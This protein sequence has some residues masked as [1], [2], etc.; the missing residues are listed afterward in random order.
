[1]KRF[2]GRVAL[3][4]GGRR[5][6]GASIVERLRA[7]GARVANL[8][9]EPPARRSRARNALEVACDVSDEAQVREAIASVVRWAGRLDVLVNNA[10]LADPH[11]AP[12]DALALEDWRRVLD[13]NL[14]GPFLVTKHA[15]P[16]LR[17]RKGT[18]INIASTRAYMSEPDT[19]AYAAS[20]GGLVALTHALALSLGPAI[21]V[22]GVAPGWIAT[23]GAGA[24]RRIDHAQHPVGRVGRPAD[25]AGLVAWLAS[26]ESGF[27]TGQTLVLDGGMTRKMIYAA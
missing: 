9:R 8:D 2:Q 10:G 22:N 5:G 23:R 24:L 21:R 11:G 7:E 1:M 19:L 18:V 16:H 6:I 3:V 13:V 26:D 14:T 4:T 17:R 27:M 25:V 20:K 12:P 15:T